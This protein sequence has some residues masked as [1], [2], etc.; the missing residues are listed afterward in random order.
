[1]V[2]YAASLTSLTLSWTTTNANGYASVEG[3]GAQ[4]G[5]GSLYLAFLL[6]AVLL[7]VYVILVLSR[8]DWSWPRRSLWAVA[9]WF[10]APVTM[11]TYYVRHVLRREG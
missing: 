10:A 3:V 8:E 2:C 5:Y 9:L 11:P 4:V 6:T 7:I 1:M